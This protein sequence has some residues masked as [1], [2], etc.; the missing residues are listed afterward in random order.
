MIAK[1][2]PPVAET[3]A[4]SRSRIN[5][6]VYERVN[7]ELATSAAPVAA[8]YAKDARWPATIRDLSVG[9]VRLSVRR[10][11]E[12]GTGLGIELIGSDG[13]PQTVLVK[14]VHAHMQEDG[15]WGLGC[16]FISELSEDELERLTAPPPA[17]PPTLTMVS[18]VE[19]QIRLSSR[20]TLG[21]RVAHMAVPGSW[22]LDPGKTVTI[23]GGRETGSPW[24]LTL[25]VIECRRQGEGWLFRCRLPRPPAPADL[26][27]AVGQLT[28]SKQ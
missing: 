17:S 5:C 2:T 6:R 1:Q 23:N 18:G 14:V 27:R 4:P 25:N 13:E 19:L 16:K 12:P 10:R 3:A 20:T 11:F 21:C 24:S 7:C 22:P 15:N 8:L 28:E 9:G 26:L